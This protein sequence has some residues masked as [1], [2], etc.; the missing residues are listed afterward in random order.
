MTRIHGDITGIKRNIIDRIENL[1]NY[2]VPSSQ[3]VTKELSD[4][5]AEIT[6][7][8]NREI[9]VYINR[10]GQLIAV[11]IGDVR[12]V[13][14]PE[15]D[16]RR[17]QSKLCGIRCIHTHPNG[18]S[19]LSSIDIAALR[20]S[21]FDVMVALGVSNGGVTEVSFS[22]IL[23]ITTEPFVVDGIGPVPADQL[24]EIDIL[25]FITRLERSLGTRAG[26][27]LTEKTEKAV[28]VGLDNSKGWN[29]VD[30]L[31]EL[32]QLAKTA[33]AEVVDVIWQKRDKPDS[34][35]FVGRGKVQ[36][37]SFLIQEKNASLVIFDNELSPAQINNLE[38]ALGIK[39]IDR[40]ALILDIFAQRA[41][42]HEG[43]LQVELAQLQYNLPRLGGLGLALSRLGGGIGTR[44]PGETKLEVDKRRIRSRISDIKQEIENLKKQRNLQRKS[45]E[46]SNVFTIALVG[47]TNAG[48]S[49]LLNT[50]TS[51]G[52]VAEDM[53]FATLDP[54][55][56]KFTMPNGRSVLITDTVGFIQKLP[57]QLVAAF[58]ATLEEVIQADLL[59]HVVDVSHPQYQQQSDE[60][61]S[62][63]RELNADNKP[64]IM[65]LNKIDKLENDGIAAAKLLRHENSVAIS[66]KSSKGLEELVAKIE[67]VLKNT[68]VDMQ[69]LIPY[70][71][72][73]ILDQFYKRAMIQ[74]TEYR[75]DG[76]FL[77][78]SLSP[79]D[80]ARFHTYVIGDE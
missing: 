44:G 10:R 30:S 71:D 23:D 76:I 8:L 50:L 79:E 40:T 52:V 38:K 72:S 56:R 5:M 55:T 16:N 7:Q 62:V 73:G 34:S 31:E 80:S 75:D 11:S 57:H 28:L 47:Y 65:A 1:Y 13:T 60:V 63:L 36:E 39:I 26:L 4:S 19:V 29:V 41:R 24:L 45:R 20:L 48:K 15:M 35:L 14:L 21:R 54:T 66:A 18:N 6:T 51:A 22:Y 17:G 25:N 27:T 12:T 61:F 68:T 59:I 49:T 43:K 67:N 74:I 70:N 77:K 64:T 2:S 3:I 69:F 46:L 42:T 53:L 78:A 37:I 9:A 58:R 32:A 33:G